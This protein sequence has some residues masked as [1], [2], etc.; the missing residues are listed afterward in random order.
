[1]LGHR[2]RPRPNIKMTESQ[3]LVFATS[4]S[5]DHQNL[6]WFGH[7][8]SSHHIIGRTV[9][10]RWWLNIYWT[11]SQRMRGCI[12]TNGNRKQTNEYLTEKNV[13]SCNA[14]N[15]KLLSTNILFFHEA[16]T[17]IFQFVIF[18]SAI[19]VRYSECW[20]YRGT[21]LPTYNFSYIHLCTI[22]FRDY[23]YITVYIYNSKVVDVRDMLEYW[24]NC[25]WDVFIDSL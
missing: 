9:H 15:K 13:K 2:R 17:S 14:L 4:H 19:L 23:M 8:I 10:I 22:I 16:D 25:D 21:I 6:L 5:H 7:P 11:L 1:M 20:Y 12:V 24:N 18:T 3:H